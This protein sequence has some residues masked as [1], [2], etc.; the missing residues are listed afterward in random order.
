MKIAVAPEYNDPAAEISYQG[1]RAMFFHIYDGHGQLAEIL[2]NF[3]A[4][5]TGRGVRP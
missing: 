1:A 4:G 2:E 5:N 3:Y